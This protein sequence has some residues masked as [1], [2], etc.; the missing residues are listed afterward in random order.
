MTGTQTPQLE[1][2]ALPSPVAFH[3]ATP[4]WNGCQTFSSRSNS[5]G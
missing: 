3:A 2:A 5:S 4:S 1:Q